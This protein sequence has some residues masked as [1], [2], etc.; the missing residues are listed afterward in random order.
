MIG[1]VEKLWYISID[2]YKQ[3]WKQIIGEWHPA[4]SENVLL[5]FL[6]AFTST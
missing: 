3:H 2:F 6:H 5:K 1:I 4:F